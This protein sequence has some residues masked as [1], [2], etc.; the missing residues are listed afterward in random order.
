MWSYAARFHLEKATLFVNLRHIGK[1]HK[2]GMH[3]R[4]CANTSVVTA[5]WLTT[6]A[7]VWHLDFTLCIAE[8]A[9]R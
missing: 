2:C 9:S 4:V 6:S 7:T 8:M 3:M 1:H 5:Y